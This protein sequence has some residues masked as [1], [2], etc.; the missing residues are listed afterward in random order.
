MFKLWFTG[1]GTDI[2]FDDIISSMGA[3]INQGG[4]IYVGSD[5]QQVESSVVFVTAIC[6]HGGRDRVGG[7][8]FFSRKKTNSTR[9][10]T[11]LNRLLHEVELSV[12]IANKIQDI[13]YVNPEVH[14]DVSPQ[15]SLTKSAKFCDMLSGYVI[16]AGFLCK[17]KPN[18]WASA[19]IADRHSK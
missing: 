8:Y 19:S 16:G 14:I 5:S 17:I 13:C 10:V 6:L 1:S 12:E 9:F 7:I 4:S 18:A 15:G 3:H 2:S 11:V